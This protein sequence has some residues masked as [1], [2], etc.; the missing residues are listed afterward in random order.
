MGVVGIRDGSQSAWRQRSSRV[1]GGTNSRLNF[2]WPSQLPSN[3]CQQIAGACGQLIAPSVPPSAIEQVNVVPMATAPTLP[4]T[5]YLL[6]RSAVTN[7]PQVG[8]A[9]RA[10]LLVLKLN[11]L[12]VNCFWLNF[13]L[14]I[15]FTWWLNYYVSM[16]RRRSAR[17]VKFA[18]IHPGDFEV[19]FW[20]Y[21]V[22]HLRMRDVLYNENWL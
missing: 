17:P 18:S 15:A 21:C 14:A 6:P 22:F 8:C 1:D 20:K 13:Y 2:A 7:N 11:H 5:S 3:L 4:A 9:L 10:V 16:S 19:R 12:L